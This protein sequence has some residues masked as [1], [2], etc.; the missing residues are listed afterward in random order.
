MGGMRKFVKT[1][2]PKA[3]S[4][5]VEKLRQLQR[6]GHRKI[7]LKRNTPSM[8]IVERIEYDP[9]RTSR[10]A[11]VRW[12]QGVKPPSH[13]RR[14]DT[15]ETPR[16]V[17]ESTMTATPRGIF[18]FCTLPGNSRVDDHRKAGQSAKDVFLSTLSAANAEGETAKVSTFGLPRIAVAGAKPGFFVP[19]LREEVKG[20]NTD[21]FSLSDVQKWRRDSILWKHRIKRKAAISWHWQSCRR[22]DTLALAAAQ[23]KPKAKP[24]KSKGEWPKARAPVTYIIASHKLEEGKVVMNCN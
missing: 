12:I 5:E 24:A 19:R 7:D 6:N 20:E 16:K 13:Q 8:G 3:A 15:V 23:H 4:S 9:N 17:L 1:L 10:L 14:C 2:T 11:L 21:A 18:S 22:Q